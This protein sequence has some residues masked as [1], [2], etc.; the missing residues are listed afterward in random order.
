MNHM[1]GK[2]TLRIGI[3]GMAIDLYQM[4]TYSVPLITISVNRN[5][6]GAG[7]SNQVCLNS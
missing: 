6:V 1:Q 4:L 5:D 7:S 3:F 2:A